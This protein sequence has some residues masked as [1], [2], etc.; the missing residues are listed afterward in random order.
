MGR[1][2]SVIAGHHLAAQAALDLLRS[3]GTAM[4][5]GIAA[6]GALSVLKPDAC[7][8]GSDLFLLYEDHATGTVHALN[9]SG[10]APRRTAPA[11]FA[12]GIDPVG[13][14][15]ATVPGAVAGWAAALERFGTRT[16]ADVL[17]PAIEIARD[18]MPVSVAFAGT[19]RANS[20]LIDRFP[21]TAAVFSPGGTLPPAGATLEQP[22]A[23]RTLGEIA[24]GGAA[25]FYNGSFA[26]AL[27]R[28]AQADGAFMRADDLHGYAADWRRPLT[29]DFRGLEIVGQPPVSVGAIVLEG[30]KILEH[31]AI[32][33][34]DDLS[35]EF[36]H[37][38]VEAMKLA[39]ADLQ[40]HIGDPQFASDDPLG[41]MLSA[42]YAAQRT[43]AIDPARAQVFAAGA[44]AVNA[45]SDTSYVAISDAYG[46]SLSLLQSVFHIFGC[47]VVV[48]G[49]GVVMNNRMTGFSIDPGSPNAVAPGK[50]ALHTLNPL[51]V[52]RNGKTIVCL[53]TPGGPSQTYTNSLV[54]LRL[55]DKG[56]D[57][58]TAV[59]APRWFVAPN[60]ALHIETS[61]GEATLAKLEALGH[62]LVR[63]TPWNAAMGGAGVLR[64]NDNG[65]RE[66]G[67]D[68]RRESYAVAY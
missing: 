61:V 27:D 45:G 6:A 23:A 52:R 66:N 25:A 17:G 42:D 15:A 54:L 39:T 19:L 58:Q 44:L 67:A 60:G 49:T 55:F 50:R 59:E 37:T 21:S 11:A 2:G 9:A 36:I 29:V 68:P 43:R 7:G 16:L 41:R 48:P 3:G 12:D 46:N 28:F 31:T 35:P 33:S 51:L 4:D 22:D 10:P 26:A 5:A 30:V 40:A 53:G 64:L 34:Y 18:G 56:Y 20:A 38:H 65:V 14:R 8:L 32:D 63:V 47:G 62:R 13:L 1:R 57:V 24:A